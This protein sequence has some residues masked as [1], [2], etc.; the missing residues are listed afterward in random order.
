MKILISV[1]F[2]NLAFS[3]DSHDI[4]V[5]Y[6]KISRGTSEYKMLVRFE[7]GDI[8]KKIG[9]YSDLGQ[10]IAT[11]LKGHLSLLFDGKRPSWIVREVEVAD[12]FI[13]INC[14]FEFQP[15]NITMINVWNTS[16][17]NSVD[18]HDNVIFPDFTI[19]KVVQT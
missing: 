2:L 13:T 18:G 19:R 11:C 7:R 15:N 6:F 14:D 5:A 16:L 12:L 8:L 9:V 3:A 10:S 1:L 17:I 4:K